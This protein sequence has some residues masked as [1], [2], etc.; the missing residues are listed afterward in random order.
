MKHV[1]STTTL[2]TLRLGFVA[3]RILQLLFPM[4]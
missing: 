3:S 4:G 1:F 2:Y